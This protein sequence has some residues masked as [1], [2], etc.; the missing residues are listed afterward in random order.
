MKILLDPTDA[1]FDGMSST[2]ARMVLAVVALVAAFLCYT[3]PHLGFDSTTLTLMPLAVVG[4]ILVWST[5]GLLFF[6]GLAASIAFLVMVRQFLDTTMPKAC[7]LALFLLGFIFFIPVTWQEQF[8][9]WKGYAAGAGFV[10]VYAMLAFLLPFVVEWYLAS[11]KQE[12]G[13]PGVHGEQIVKGIIAGGGWKNTYKTRVKVR[14][15]GCW[16]GAIILAACGMEFYDAA[17][18]WGFGPAALSL[19]AA[20][21]LWVVERPVEWELPCG[22]ERD[23]R[24]LY[25]KSEKG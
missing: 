17:G 21:V 24:K 10:V 19:G 15:W 16:F 4:M 23:L 14:A 12:K 6:V 3:V 5:K 20:I 13:G 2:L 1:I 8:A 11:K 9:G 25:G 18:F 22:E 7:F